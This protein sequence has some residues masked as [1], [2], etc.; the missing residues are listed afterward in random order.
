MLIDSHCHIDAAEF[1]S[2]RTAVI[3]AARRAGVKGLLVPAVDRASWQRIAELANADADLYPAYGLH[4]MFLAEHTEADIEAL[5]AWVATHRC[6]AIGEC[7][8]DFYVPELDHAR[9]LEILRPQLALARQLDRPVILHARRALDP[10]LAEIKRVG[11]LRG[12][13]HSFSGSAEQARQWCAQGFLLGFGG[14]VTYERAARLRRVMAELPLQ[15]LV[16]ET[17]AP[18]QPLSGHQSER[19]TPAQLTEV[20]MCV[21]S[22]RGMEPEALAMATSRNVLDLLAHR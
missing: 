10:L 15:H 1:D 22:L 5:A 4:P 9:Q 19:N 7:G 6:S 21:A 12:I 14:P 18:D 17:D 16:L 3:A 8:L 11:R 13:V 20:L 2:D